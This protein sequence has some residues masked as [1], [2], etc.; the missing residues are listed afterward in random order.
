MLP[1]P[2]YAMAAAIG[3]VAGIVSWNELLRPA[4]DFTLRATLAHEDRWDLFGNAPFDSV[5]GSVL[6]L[7]RA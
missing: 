6:N 5:A 3:I 1:V 7:M 4:G 2:V